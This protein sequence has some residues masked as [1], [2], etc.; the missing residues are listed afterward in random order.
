MKLAQW[1][2]K[3]PGIGLRKVKSVIAVAIAFV[4]WQIVRWLVSPELEV[5]PVFGYVYAVVELRETPEKT[6]TFSFYRIKATLIGLALGLALL[7][8]SVFM[9]KS[10]PNA[11]VLHLADLALILAGVL[12]LGGIALLLFL[13]PGAATFFKICL[14]VI[15]ILFIL[16]GL[17]LLYVLYLGR[18]NN[19]NFFLYDTKT[20]RNIPVEDLGFDRVNSRMSYFMTTLTTS[21]EK[22]WSENA[23]NAESERFGVNEVYKPLAAYKMLY[24]LGEIDSPEGWQLFLCAAPATIDTLADALMVN[25]EEAMVQA[26]RHAYNSAAGRDDIDWIRDFVMGNRKYISRRMMGYV[27]KNM[28]QFY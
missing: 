16:M 28:E 23:L 20:Q 18:D 13:V 12:I 1:R 25:G 14:V 22:L 6:R 19:P 10:I 8:L 4:I 2:S 15:S 21:Q 27:R 7:P 11:F 26:L 17:G 5:H 9:E 3:I 24:D